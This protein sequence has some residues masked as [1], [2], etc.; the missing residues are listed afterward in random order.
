MGKERWF[1]LSYH[2]FLDDSRL[3]HKVDWVD[4]PQNVD[5][6]IAKYYSEFAKIVRE[7]GIPKFVTYD[8]DL[9]DEHYQAFFNLRERYPLEYRNFKRRCGIHCVEMLIEECRRLNIPHPEYR[10]HTKNHYAEGSMKTIIELYNL[11][12][13]KHE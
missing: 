2:L 11:K 8:C 4:L 7:R 10:I 3:P 9:C 5:W 6:V 1:K 13:K 12:F